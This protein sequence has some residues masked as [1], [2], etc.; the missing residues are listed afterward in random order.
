MTK[1][2]KGVSHPHGIDAL[3]NV[4][5]ATEETLPPGMACGL[6]TD[7]DRQLLL[8]KVKGYM[9]GK[10]P[11][12]AYLRTLGAT[13]GRPKDKLSPAKRLPREKHTILWMVD[14]LTSQG[15]T[16]V[17]HAY[18]GATQDL[19]YPGL[20]YMADIRYTNSA[21]VEYFVEVNGSHDM[22]P[23]KSADLA[24]WDYPAKVVAVSVF[25]G[26]VQ[27]LIQS[28]LI[29]DQVSNGVQKFNKLQATA[30]HLLKNKN[31]GYQFITFMTTLGGVYADYPELAMEKAGSS[32]TI[33]HADGHLHFFVTRSHRNPDQHL[34]AKMKGG[35]FKGV[36]IN[37][38]ID[39]DN[40]YGILPGASEAV[41]DQ[42]LLRTARCQFRDLEVQIP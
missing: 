11:V 17:A 32:V 13:P 3:G 25:D 26:D 41:K 29:P 23:A 38:K 39:W 6:R 18:G 14:W 34:I 36:I 1:K 22:P 27:N 42:F 28:T 8:T 40:G 21:G 9:R 2:K 10:T 7:D 31:A 4:R 16:V 12:D 20:D 33:R 15:G 30:E 5:I 37:E 19:W 24:A 35:E